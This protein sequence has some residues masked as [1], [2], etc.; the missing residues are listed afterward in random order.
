[1]R[2]PKQV[3]QS[4]VLNQEDINISTKD[5]FNVFIQ[6]RILENNPFV[7]ITTFSKSNKGT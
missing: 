1:M 4:E 6:D 2:N 3:R 7:Q 5:Y